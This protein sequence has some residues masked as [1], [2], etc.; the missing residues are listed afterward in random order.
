MERRICCLCL[1]ESLGISSFHG[2]DMVVTWQRL[3]EASR[4]SQSPRSRCAEVLLFFSTHL[5]LDSDSQSLFNY[6]G[7]SSNMVQAG[8]GHNLQMPHFRRPFRRPHEISTILLWMS[9]IWLFDPTHP[10][11]PTVWCAKLPGS[12]CA[13]LSQCRRRAPH[14]EWS[15][16]HDDKRSC[17][18]EISI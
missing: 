16:Y 12:E 17:P 10:T 14:F 4:G 2:C 9:L 13:H 1:L 18:A 6:S 3:P 5:A 11:H 7:V 15:C 8:H